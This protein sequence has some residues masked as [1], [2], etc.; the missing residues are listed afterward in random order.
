MNIS[1]TLSHSVVGYAQLLGSHT[2]CMLL[3][4]S[5]LAASTRHISSHSIVGCI[6]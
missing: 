1:H 3:E 2:C 6:P 5:S 4:L